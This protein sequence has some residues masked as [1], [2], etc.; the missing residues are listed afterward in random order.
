MI[1]IRKYDETFETAKTRKLRRPKWLQCETGLES[2]GIVNLFSHYSPQE[3]VNAYG[4]FRL[5]VDLLGTQ[6]LDVV[7]QVP[8]KWEVRA[9][10]GSPLTGRR[11]GILLHT[12]G[13]PME[14]A[15]L[16][17]RFRVEPSQ[18]ESAVQCLSSQYVK[19]INFDGECNDLPLFA[20]K[21]P[22]NKEVGK[23]NGS[24][25]TRDGEREDGALESKLSPWVQPALNSI[26]QAWGMGSSMNTGD[27]LTVQQVGETWPDPAGDFRLI[28]E[29]LASKAKPGP[30]SFATTLSRLGEVR[31]WAREWNEDRENYGKRGKGPKQSKDQ[32]K[33]EFEA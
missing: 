9:R 25:H 21:G 19:W 8:E 13:K 26:C 16:A 18:I 11:S 24:T 12:D 28:A 23:G 22:W 29:F 5:F 2:H 4:L 7:P 33:S 3:A 32:G 6:P 31:D 27:F 15:F 10:N 17:R 20:E 30:R 1:Q 14:I